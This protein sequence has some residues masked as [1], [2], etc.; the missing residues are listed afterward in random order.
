M[1]YSKD[2]YQALMDSQKHWDSDHPIMADYN[3]DLLTLAILNLD[4]AQEVAD[5][6]LEYAC[7]PSEKNKEELDQELADNFLFTLQLYSL[8]GVDLY[9]SVMTKRAYNY[10]RYTSHLFSN[11][12]SYHEAKT[13]GRNWA[14]ERHWK[15]HFYEQGA[16]AS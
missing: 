12:N 15:D 6:A 10:T 1:P 8:I 7:D 13:M 9:D 3:T 11:G 5:Q 4:E 16:K 14:A 2:R